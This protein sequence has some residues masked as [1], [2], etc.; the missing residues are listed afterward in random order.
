VIICIFYCTCVVV[1]VDCYS[2]RSI[3][4]WRSKI[5]NRIEIFFFIDVESLLFY[6]II[7]II[8]FFLLNTFNVLFAKNLKLINNDTIDNIITTIA[9]A[10][11]PTSNSN[12]EDIYCASCVRCCAL[13][14]FFEFNHKIMINV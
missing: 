4:P 3:K 13:G 2:Y 7:I 9:S 6:I 8:L 5:L 14:T 12:S 11:A 10:R 1:Y